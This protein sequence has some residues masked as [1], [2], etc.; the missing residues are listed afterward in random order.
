MR[1]P[2]WHDSALFLTYDEHGGFFD[3][4]PP[5]SAPIPDAIPPMLGP[6]NYQAAF[7]R[8]GIRVPFAVISPFAKRHFV[9]HTVHDHTS[10][11]KTIE[12]RFGLQPLTKRDAAAVPL[13]DMFNFNHPAFEQPPALAAATI[14]PVHALD[15]EKNEQPP[16]GF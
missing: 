10:I 13:T 7:D 4:V 12:L 6:G 8:L 15:C 11:L 1:S 9:S 3:H 14:D 2:N 16:T 5:P